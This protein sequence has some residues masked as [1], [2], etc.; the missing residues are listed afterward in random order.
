MLTSLLLRPHLLE[1]FSD[2]E[3]DVQ[4]PPRE[5]DSEQP[6]MHLPQPLRAHLPRAPQ[7]QY[8]KEAGLAAHNQAL[9]QLSPWSRHLTF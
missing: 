3:M 7:W 1:H 4:G 5:L 2:K 8:K 9:V 6:T